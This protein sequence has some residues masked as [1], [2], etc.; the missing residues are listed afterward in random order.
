MLEV[1]L[2]GVCRSPPLCDLVWELSI[3]KMFENVQPV[4]ISMLKYLVLIYT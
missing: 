1:E 4:F 3:E 2:Q